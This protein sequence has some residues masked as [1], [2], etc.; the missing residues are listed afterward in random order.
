MHVSGAAVQGIIRIEKGNTAASRP[1]GKQS[2]GNHLL[3]WPEEREIPGLEPG[4]RVAAGDYQE[5]SA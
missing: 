1:C 4:P 3:L 5:D 2:E